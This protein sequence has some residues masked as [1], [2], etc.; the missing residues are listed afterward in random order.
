MVIKPTGYLIAALA[1]GGLALCAYGVLYSFVPPQF[2]PGT[3]AFAFR[4]LSTLPVPPDLLRTADTSK[5]WS[6]GYLGKD[7]S[8]VTTMYSGY[9]PRVYPLSEGAFASVRCNGDDNYRYVVDH[10][11][12]VYVGGKR[13]TD[14]S[15]WKPCTSVE[16][17]ATNDESVGKI[18][19][20]GMGK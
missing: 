13:V 14:F 2:Q 10:Q 5:P 9:G 15:G 1:V 17:R 8:G 4:E 11:G 12:F 7:W 6:K 3:D 18:Y 16:V 19:F 20:V